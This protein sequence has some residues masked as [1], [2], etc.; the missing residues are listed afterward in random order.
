MSKVLVL[1]YLMLPAYCANM[2][3][4]FARFWPGWN[5]PI[6][7]KRLGEHKTVIGFG[8]GVLAALLVAWAQARIAW[9]GALIDYAWWPLIGLAAGVG[10]LGGDALKSWF[11]RAR[12]IAPGASWVPADQLD[13]VLGALLLLWP[14]A[15]W[16]WEDVAIILA[17]SF[18]GDIA[19]NHIAY[20]LRIRDTKW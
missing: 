10:A 19:I 20:W 17:V 13:F 12:G 15:R 11:K 2:A 7:P 8:F 9:A 5:R 4:P 3:A 6:N 16:G 18:V 14:W 1:L